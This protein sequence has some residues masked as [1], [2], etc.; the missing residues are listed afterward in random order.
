M[1]GLCWDCAGTVLMGVVLGIDY[2]S[3]ICYAVVNY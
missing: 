1:L 3:P 2:L